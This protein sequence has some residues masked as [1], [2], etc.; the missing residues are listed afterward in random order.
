VEAISHA[1]P[2]T[3]NIYAF[4]SQSLDPT[5]FC[6]GGVAYWEQEWN[7]GLLNG[8]TKITEGLAD[9]LTD[10]INPA[11]NQPSPTDVLKNLVG[12]VGNTEHGL[13]MS[14]RLGSV[15][16]DTQDAWPMGT[17]ILQRNE[18]EKKRNSQLARVVSQ[19]MQSAVQEILTFNT[20]IAEKSASTSDLIT[21]AECIIKHLQLLGTFDEEE[22]IPLLYRSMNLAG[23][24]V[25]HPFSE[26]MFSF[27]HACMHFCDRTEEGR[28]LH[29]SF[30]LADPQ[31]VTPLPGARPLPL[32][33]ET[34]GMH[35]FIKFDELHEYHYLISDSA[36]RCVV[37]PPGSI[38]PNLKEEIP[39]FVIDT[40]PLFATISDGARA[41]IWNRPDAIMS[42]LTA[43]TPGGIGAVVGPGPGVRLYAAGLCLAVRDGREWSVRSPRSMFT[44]CMG[45]IPECSRVPMQ[46]LTELS[47]QLSPKINDKNSGGLLLWTP[48]SDAYVRKDCNAKSDQV[49]ITS[50]RAAAPVRYASDD[51]WLNGRSTVS[52]NKDQEADRLDPMSIYARIDSS[53]A[54]LLLRAAGADGAVCTYGDTLTILDFAQKIS[55][56]QSQ[57]LTELNKA[58]TKRAAAQDFAYSADDGRFAIA[59]S[60]DG[61]IRIYTQRTSPKMPIYAFCTPKTMNTE[62]NE[63]WS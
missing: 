6:V 9:C 15:M 8:L 27:L 35:R 14:D 45:S 56:V 25:W 18:P 53:V 59:V 50:L 47:L 63:Y 44:R 49:T 30:M 39:S 54:K 12:V 52:Q 40:T 10:C 61:P 29:Y 42:R 20:A 11:M 43:C 5:G 37:L 33:V 31:F 2:H 24:D 55:P 57:V 36:R 41:R 16:N 58:G 23:D 62:L 46:I 3:N 26:C 22:S 13:N 60:S 48:S 1:M 21:V 34:A 51:P 32:T 28:P 4:N 7:P 17:E 19:S 38:I